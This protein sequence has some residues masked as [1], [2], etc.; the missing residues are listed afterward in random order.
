[1][2]KTSEREGVLIISSISGNYISAKIKPTEFT[3]L[4]PRFPC[5]KFTGRNPTQPPSK[6]VLR[7][8]YRTD[9]HNIKCCTI[10]LKNRAQKFVA[11][12]RRPY[13]L[14]GPL[15]APFSL[16]IVLLYGQNRNIKC[17]CTK[18]VP[19]RFILLLICLEIRALLCLGIRATFLLQF[20]LRKNGN[21][22]FSCSLSIS[23]SLLERMTSHLVFFLL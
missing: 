23:Q 10:C 16:E 14:Y 21:F 5:L 20:L 15:N 13:S 12:V 1:V 11:A 18:S 17:G 3:Y 2:G 22:L 9:C 19:Y 7:Q 8:P 4:F 6:S